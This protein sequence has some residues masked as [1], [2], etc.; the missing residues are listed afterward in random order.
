MPRKVDPYIEQRVK[1]VSNR[2]TSY[3]QIKGVLK[4]EGFDVSLQSISRILNGRGK[5]RAA[6]VM[7]LVTP[8]R[9]RKPVKATNKVIKKLDLLT[10]SENP[11]TQRDMASRL[12]I[13]P[14][15]I[16][17]LIRT[18][19]HKVVRKKRNVH[20]LTDAHKINRKTNSRKLYEGHIAGEK[21]KFAVTLDEAYFYVN[22]CN[23][24]RSIYYRKENA[25][26]E[27]PVKPRRESY[28]CKFMVVGGMTGKGLLPLFRV[29]SKVKV[30]S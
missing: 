15:L 22:D 29:P 1:A 10:S 12:K 2:I 7:G 25:D 30:N 28:E 17:T 5:S 27:P 23:A 19:L 24:P 20:R 18:K 4:D 11:M 3:R 8:P 21:F 14:S 9:I 26:T 16:N 13:S 6:R